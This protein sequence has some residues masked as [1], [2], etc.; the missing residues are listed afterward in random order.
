MYCDVSSK[1]EFE[2]IEETSWFAEFKNR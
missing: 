2:E 1:I